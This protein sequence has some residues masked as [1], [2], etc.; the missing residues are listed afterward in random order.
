N[1]NIAL[2]VSDWLNANPDDVNF[3][4]ADDVLFGVETLV[5]GKRIRAL[6]GTVEFQC[7]ASSPMGLT[8]ALPWC[9]D[10]NPER[11]AQPPEHDDVGLNILVAEDSDES[12][13]LTEILLQHE[14]VWRAQNGLEAVDL[15]K[16]RRFDVV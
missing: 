11:S 16:K 4:D 15:V 10:A 1:S 3:K 12:F 7:D 14:S 2:R 9:A 6:G 8:I 13:V 5:A